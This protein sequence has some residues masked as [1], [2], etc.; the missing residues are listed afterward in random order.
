MTD[1]SD[2][3]SYYPLSCFDCI[4]NHTTSSKI[5]YF[6]WMPLVILVNP[7]LLAEQ[8]LGQGSHF[9][10][11]FGLICFTINLYGAN[12]QI[13]RKLSD[14]HLLLIG[15]KFFFFTVH[16]FCKIQLLLG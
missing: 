11:E 8:Y 1:I 3:F 9:I 4:G 14:I 13:K 7:K 16:I 5:N 2:C 6:P 12:L 10:G 15:L